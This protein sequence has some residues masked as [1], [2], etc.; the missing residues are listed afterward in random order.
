MVKALVLEMNMRISYISEEVSTIYFGGGTPSLLSE[1]E[2]G[3]LL[4]NIRKNFSVSSSAEI[5]LEA[6]PDD[7]SREKLKQ[8]KRA[9]IN[10]LSIGVQS[11]YD[12]DLIFMNR[13]H[14]AE[15]SQ[16]CIIH[17]REEG[18]NN[19]SIDLIFALPGRTIDWLQANIQKALKLDPEHISCYGLTVESRT[20]LA[21]Q[22]KKGIVTPA[23][24]SDFTQ[25]YSLLMNMLRDNGYEHYEIS[26][27]AKPGYLSKHN[28]SY[29]KGESY[30]GLGPSAHSFNQESRQ[31][32]IRNNHQYVKALNE[33][34]DYFETEELTIGDKI[35]EYILTS[36]RT[37]WGTDLQVLLRLS[38]DLFDEIMSEA[39]RHLEEGRLMISENK[40]LLTEN[41]KFLC[42]R[43]TSD[44]FVTNV[45]THN[46]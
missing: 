34:G 3:Y 16:Q 23:S 7:L 6:N 30:L 31:W 11:F 9:G 17:A 43:I 13:S 45:R 18:F 28:T 38:G 22:V 27:F 19:I 8:L 32:N 29:W 44:L 42:D 40:L 26:N 25:Q 21:S 4:E 24:D 20:V 12:E 1:E 35:N 15:Q 33:G 39:N 14:S 46:T 37:C 41:G 10:R 2:L 5:T 36:L